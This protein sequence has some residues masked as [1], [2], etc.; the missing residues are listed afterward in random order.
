MGRN[1]IDLKGQRLG[2]FVV[3][4]REGISSDGHARWL[5]KCSCGNLALIPSNKLKSEGIRSCGCLTG[6][7][8]K[9]GMSA[10]N[11]YTILAAMKNRCLNPKD[12]DY[13]NYG[14]RGITVCDRWLES[15]ESFFEDMGRRPKGLS[16]ERVDNN[17]NY[18]PSNCVWATAKEQANNRRTPKQV[19]EDDRC[20]A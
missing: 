7:A 2:L 6:K 8:I 17:G 5:C 10:S 18:E 11:E 1:A 12:K 19:R 9:H 16:V 14:G 4:R 15:F 20:Q 13:K 3:L